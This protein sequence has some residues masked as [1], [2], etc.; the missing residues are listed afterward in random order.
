MVVD[1]ANPGPKATAAGEVR[2]R[3]SH[4]LFGYDVF[5]SYR[6]RDAAAYAS[7]LALK[8]RAD[9]DLVVFLDDREF[10]VGEQLPVLLR[11]AR[12][13]RMLIVLVSAGIAGSR[14]VHREVAAAQAKGRRI[15]PI[16][17]DRTLELG[18]AGDELSPLLQQ[19]K[20]EAES[21]A[22]ADGPSQRILDAIA[23]S[24]RGLKRRTQQRLFFVSIVLALLALSGYAFYLA[25]Q[26]ADALFAQT[27]RTEQAR[28]LAYSSQLLL[29]NE[30]GPREPA[31]AQAVLD[32][33]ERC[34]LDLR[35]VTWGLIAAASR[36]ELWSAP[37]DWRP[38]RMLG[39]TS[40][41]GLLTVADD[42]RVRLVRPDG[43]STAE[44]V[45]T[46]S[47]RPLW[48]DPLSNR[49]ALLAP[50]GTVAIWNV[51][52]GSELRRIDPRPAHRVSSAAE[53]SEALF[54]GEAAAVVA[55]ALSPGGRTLATMSRKT[56]RV[57][58]VGSGAE[59][60]PRR[61]DVV[62][63]GDEGPSDTLVAV[64]PSAAEP[65]RFLLLIDSDV[66]DG[67]HHSVMMRADADGTS[68]LVARDV[69]ARPLSLAT[70]ARGTRVAMN[71]RTWDPEIGQYSGHSRVLMFESELAP[72]PVLTHLLAQQAVTAIALTSDGRRLAMT[73][74]RDVLRIVDAATG[75]LE[76][77]LRVAPGSSFVAA[78]PSGN[79]FAV[80]SKD[81]RAA[82]LRA[83]P[84]PPGRVLETRENRVS[85][86]RVRSFQ[87]H[88]D[89]IVYVWSG[90][91]LDSDGRHFVVDRNTGDRVGDAD[92][93]YS[94]DFLGHEHGIADLLTN[95]VPGASAVSR[96]KTWLIALDHGTLDWSRISKLKG[97]A[98]GGPT[99][100]HPAS[101]RDKESTA[102]VE[103]SPDGGQLAILRL[104]EEVEVEPP[105]V[106]P[107]RTSDG[108]WLLEILDADNPAAATRLWSGTGYPADLAWS[109]DGN[110]V[111]LS[112]DQGGIKLWRTN[113]WRASADVATGGRARLDFA[114]D[115]TTLAATWHSGEAAVLALIDPSRSRVAARIPL[116][117]PTVDVVHAVSESRVALGFADGRVAVVD[118]PNRQARF[119]RGPGDS[120][121]VAMEASDDR[122]T[123][124]VTR[125]RKGDLILCTLAD[126]EFGHDI[127]ELRHDGEPVAAAAFLGGGRGV[128]MATESGVY[129]W[130][131][132]PPSR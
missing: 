75:M 128:L 112:L 27:V 127:L 26:R 44:T 63:P 29:A 24:R 77:E 52:E 21:N 85:L 106:T 57:W 33:L 108:P 91:V 40:D 107:I 93:F 124:L 36:R 65:E 120:R 5:I 76:A 114:R 50:D 105:E 55:A 132:A 48:F 23:K 104:S 4:A 121:V 90:L 34:P 59:I 99:P 84:Q 39:Y 16:D 51:A 101:D 64:H 88:G 103:P 45:G 11:A 122:K 68:T 25:D 12:R 86:K 47:G 61:F 6:R 41:D 28:R 92:Q 66:E 70:A 96:G 30:L 32:D 83:A 125:L 56:V 98:A 117:A 87:R 20:W 8:L 82:V 80:L 62:N 95:I 94:A 3:W 42:G 110:W 81:G 119:A 49:L 109:A 78:D 126:G 69:S 53:P 10:E 19:E 58:D 74:D 97:D 43:S 18:R 67:R 46:A 115:G 31:R 60:G 130:L 2:P 71:V 123:L 118:V 1:A 111:A 22:L 131:A 116:Q 89:S 129:R 7:A 17:F 13:S 14:F 9:Q 102:R 54:R 35:D 72:K 73:T 79:R 100:G 37:A 113:D 15:I 38:Q